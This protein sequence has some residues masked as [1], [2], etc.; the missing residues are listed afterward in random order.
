MAR[1]LKA[2]NDFNIKFDR[3]GSELTI[4]EANFKNN[5][6]CNTNYKGAALQDFWD[7]VEILWKDENLKALVESKSFIKVHF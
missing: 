2:K 5:Y 7:L 4:A 3:N 1:I 6:D